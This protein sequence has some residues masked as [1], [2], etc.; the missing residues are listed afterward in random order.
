MVSLVCACICCE[1]HE[2]PAWL[3]FVANRWTVFHLSK[4]GKRENEIIMG[5]CWEG[6]GGRGDKQDKWGFTS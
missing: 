5:S 3:S 4:C 6:W 1:K 2:F